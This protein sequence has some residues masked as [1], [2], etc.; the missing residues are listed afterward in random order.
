MQQT[1]QLRSHLASVRAHE[2]LALA[3]RGAYAAALHAA[4]QSAAIDPTLPHPH[5]IAA[6]VHFW[7][8]GVDEAERALREAARRGL[9]QRRAAAMAASIASFRE[10][11]RIIREA[12]ELAQARRAKARRSLDEGWT[13]LLGWFT[14]QRLTMILFLLVVL[15]ALSLGGL[16]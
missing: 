4:A 15:C 10:R 6:K 7:C 14:D 16:L 13:A 3:R 1:K 11:V 12:E 9:D 8:G 5:A 2:A